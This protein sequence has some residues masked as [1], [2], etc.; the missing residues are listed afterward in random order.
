MVWYTAVKPTPNSDPSERRHCG[1][2]LPISLYIDGLRLTSAR[3]YRWRSKYAANQEF[4]LA[5]HPQPE[6]PHYP[7]H[8]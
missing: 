2:R 1:F 4:Y 7:T 6:R 3:A 5:R 8:I